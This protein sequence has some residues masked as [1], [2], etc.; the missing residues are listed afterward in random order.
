MT[1]LG[2]TPI[3]MRIVPMQ[4]S[5]ILSAMSFVMPPEF[6]TEISLLL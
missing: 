4:F 5:I 2:E 1:K 3:G 6:R